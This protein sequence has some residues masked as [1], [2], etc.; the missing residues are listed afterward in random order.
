MNSL[1]EAEAAYGVAVNS[2]GVDITLDGSADRR[3]ESRR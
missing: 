3:G 2:K 1:N